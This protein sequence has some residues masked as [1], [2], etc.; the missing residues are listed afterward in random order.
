VES[1]NKTFKSRLYAQITESGDRNWVAKLPEIA[2]VINTTRPS[3][4][5]LH[6][7]P[8]E[9]WYG[10]PP[11]Q[12]TPSRALSSLVTAEEEEDDESESAE[13]DK[14]NTQE[15]LFTELYKKV[16]AYNALKAIKY[17]KRGGKQTS[18]ELNQIVLLAIPRKNRLTIEA[19]R[20]PARVIK[21]VKG[22]YTLLSQH[23]QLKGSHQASSLVPV[24]S[25]E[26]FD[27]PE[28]A[29]K[30]AKPIALSTAVTKANNRKSISA[31]QKA[32]NRA[33]KKRKRNGKEPAVEREDTF[34]YP[35]TRVERLAQQEAEAVVIQDELDE[36]FAHDTEVATAR[37]RAGTLLSR[38]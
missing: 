6:V 20:L 4:L 33:T 36:Q 35:Q 38:P 37:K 19:S 10:R 17:A 2:K 32:G 15:Y 24:L 7:T 12:Q 26:D 25:G 5:P 27:I 22:A 14:D 31:M 13:E 28:A 21:I 34:E 8:F 23:G 18:Y 9:V 1:A 3:G 16:F 11:T 30:G 29:E